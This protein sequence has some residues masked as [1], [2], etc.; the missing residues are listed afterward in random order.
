MNALL[1]FAAWALRALRNLIP[2]IL[3]AAE[4][5][6]G[7]G[8]IMTMYIERETSVSETAVQELENWNAWRTEFVSKVR[9]T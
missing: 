4:I 7:V 9:F 2:Q 5:L 6:L 8:T 3:D 1:A